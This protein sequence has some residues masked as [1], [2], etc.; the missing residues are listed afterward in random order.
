MCKI[1]VFIFRDVLKVLLRHQETS[2]FSSRGIPSTPPTP[3]PDH[4]LARHEGAWGFPGC[5]RA[6]LFGISGS[7][8]FFEVI[9]ILWATPSAAS[10]WPLLIALRLCDSWHF[11][12]QMLHS[13]AQTCHLVSL[14]PHLRH[15]GG[16]WDDHGALG[17]TRK[18]TLGS[19]LWFFRFFES[20][21]VH[22]F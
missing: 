22:H 16:P 20:I 2:L 13:G 19:R 6:M 7:G 4:P 8:S 18:D 17:S 15:L 5:H 9:V 3:A 14:V 21:S 10:P 1:S 12:G 11:W